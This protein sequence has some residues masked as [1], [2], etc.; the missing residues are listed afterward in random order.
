MAA[1]VPPK[2]NLG[3]SQAL[4][5]A[6]ATVTRLANLIPNVATDL[7]PV[8]V[9]QPGANGG[10]GNQLTANPGNPVNVNN[11]YGV[12]IAPDLNGD[13]SVWY[14]TVECLGGGGGG[15]GGIAAQ[16]GGGG[17]GAEYAREDQY[18]IEPGKS[19]AYV[20]GLP[21]SGGFNNSSGLAPPG[22]AATS[23]GVTVFD[24]AGVGLAGGVIANA[25]NG[26]DTTSVG[27]GGTG[28]TGSLNS[29][30][31]PGGNGGTNVSGNASDN[32]ISLAQ[33]SGMFVGNTLSTGI[34]KAWY[35]ENDTGHTGGL[36]NDATFNGNILTNTNYTGGLGLNN[37]IPPN[38]VPSFASPPGTYGTN[39][40]AVNV[41]RIKIGSGTSASVRQTAKAF[42]FT[43]TKLTVS[44]WLQCDPTGTWGNP[45]LG[46]SAVIA[47]NTQNYNTSAMKGYALWIRGTT[48][49]SAQLVG[50]VGDGT[51]ARTAVS[52]TGFVP[53]PGTWYYVVMTYNA[54]TLS[55]YVNNVLIQT[56]SS[57]GYTS[58]PASAFP[59]TLAIDPGATNANWFF[60]SIANLWLATDCITTTG[61]NQAFGTT[62]ATGGAGGGASGG[63]SLAGGNGA[64]ASG[65][66]AGAGGTPAS[67][68][69]SL[70][71]VSTAAM[72]GFAGANA[73]AGNS[74]PI[75][76]SGGPYGGG[77]GGSGNMTSPPALIPAV[78]QFSAGATYAGIDATSN[79]G[80]PYNTNQQ[81][82]P[83]TGINT[84]LY[85]GGLASDAASGSK[86][87]VLL[88][89]KGIAAA[90][91]S[92]SYTITSVLLTLTNA[93]P[94]NPVE[95]VL[96]VGYSSD[97]TL[98][99][100][101]N[102]ASLIDYAGAIEIPVGAGTI[103]YDLTQTSLVAQIVNGTATALILG[104]GANPT[105][106]AYNAPTGPQFYCAV[107]GPGAYD[108]AGNPLFPYLTITLQKTITT[109]RGSN[110]QGGG[111][112]V[113]AVN[114]ANT[115][116]VFIEPFA[117]TD[118]SGNQFAQGYTGQTANF[119]P[120]SLNPGSYKP[121]TWKTIS[122][123]SG[124]T[125]TIRYRKL[126]ESNFAVLDVLCTIVSTLTSS[127]T[128]TAG[129][130]NS[131]YW[132]LSGRNYPAAFN[133]GVSS[134][135]IAGPIIQ[136]TSGGVVSIICEPFASAGIACIIQ[137]TIIF[138]L[139]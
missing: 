98:P 135:A 121:E 130:L 99:Q 43:G 33:T 108:T 18:P 67:Q 101:Y 28:G 120:T 10:V 19:Y 128:Y 8:T 81:A 113:T 133:Q 73:N 53:V 91:N 71:G 2:P 100:T 46:S 85:A 23:G 6:Q 16:G 114:N 29:V 134:T 93:F 69:A 64:T 76:P 48:G 32:P 17:G 126:A 65:A 66:T 88:L 14:A 34:I 52:D 87:S 68:P 105:F 72:G 31:F 95:S 44:C 70:I 96:E 1:S 15:G 125:G 111:I 92:A 80:S 124:V 36:L 57:V 106:D 102:G 25:G 117:G 22:S 79:P 63:P 54:G 115:P 56:A 75:T 5:Q 129:T 90:I 109:Q 39:A 3:K 83:A 51:H 60:G 61:I 55:L 112:L 139:D 58:I 7:S 45:A 30:H 77:G 11:S 13:G 37:T 136:I 21:G 35:I 26:G 127:H 78:Y 24:L 104:P 50:C 132:P 84:L 41:G 110:G 12:W 4:N 59:T 107:Y 86:N 38:Q 137:G 97:T 94:S 116:V 62:S 123:P 27:I 82:N 118:A 138:P 40:T 20:V 47:A 49:S 74:S 42:S 122:N 9:Y 131:Q 89:P 119:D 103:T